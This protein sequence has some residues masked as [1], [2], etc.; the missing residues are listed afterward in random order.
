MLFADMRSVFLGFLLAASVTLLQSQDALYVPHGLADRYFQAMDIWNMPGRKVVLPNHANTGNRFYPR[1]DVAERFFYGSGKADPNHFMNDYLSTDNPDRYEFLVASRRKAVGP[2][3]KTPAQL[4]FWKDSGD[5][6]MVNPVLNVQLQPGAA[7][8]LQQNTRGAEFRGNITSKLSFYSLITENQVFLPQFIDTIRRKYGVV[9]GEGFITPFKKTG[10][11]FLQARGYLTLRA[12]K[13]RVRIQAGHDKM[14]IGNGIR[15]L[16]L[17]DHSREFLHLRLHTSLGPFRYQNI[18]ARLNGY[19]PNTGDR[20][21]PIK[22]MAIHRASVQVTRNLEL[23]LSEMV[24]FD[25][26]DSS[27][28]RGFDAD[29]L[30][31]VI[32]YRA[33]EIHNGSRD[34]AMLA[35]DWKWNMLQRF[36]WYGQVMLDEFRLEFMRQRS[37]WWG[38]KYGLQTGLKYTVSKPQFGWLFVQAEWNRV[39]PYTYTHYLP[40]QSYTHYNQPLAHP[41][42]SNFTEYVFALQY[43]PEVLPGLFLKLD[44]MLATRG[45]DSMNGKNYGNDIRLNY[46]TRA[47]NFNQRMHQGYATQNISNTQVTLSYMLRHNVF[48][49]LRWLLRQTKHNRS[50]M[51]PG[52]A[53]MFT[54][55][56]RM[57]IE[58]RNYLQ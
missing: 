18:F 30:N 45:L 47:G 21:Q 11:D 26:S 20:L 56:L 16:I 8:V 31:P 6:F 39:R 51:E 33:V 17:S 25:R 36:Q 43:Q 37:G 24:I 7:N 57:N 50:G 14:F 22:Y 23:G 46:T 35:F 10:A 49:D 4:L 38:N 5:A 15:S 28:Q 44:V 58:P 19:T 52:R 48:L 1:A 40:L 55:G 29:Y 53:Q 13:N 32:L 9:P 34:N 42:G 3:Y 2:F 27:R 54:V 12:L 41:L